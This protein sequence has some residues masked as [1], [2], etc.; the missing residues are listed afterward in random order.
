MQVVS[1]SL[2]IKKGWNPDVDSYSAFFDNKKVSCTELEEGLRGFGITDCYVCG[3]ATDVCVGATAMHSFELG[4]RTIMVEDACRG[5][6]GPAIKK[7]KEAVRESH[8]VVCD[9]SEV[10]Y[11]DI[12][13]SF[14]FL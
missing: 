3:I 6:D 4:F 2:V 13:L 8:G 12:A 1:N 10:M 5:I 14:D 7:T 11:N 9:S